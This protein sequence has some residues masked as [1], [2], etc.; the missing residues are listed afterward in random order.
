LS[1][2]LLQERVPLVLLSSE[3]LSLNDFLYQLDILLMKLWPP[4]HGN[5]LIRMIRSCCERVTSW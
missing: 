4:I 2:D 1:I 3:V 5:N